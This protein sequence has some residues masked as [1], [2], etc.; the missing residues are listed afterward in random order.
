[1]RYDFF[2]PG[3]E[4]MFEVTKSVAEIYGKKQI[5]GFC[6]SVMQRDFSGVRVSK[7]TKQYGR[8][9][10]SDSLAMNPNQI[11][12]HRKL[13]PDI[14]VTKEGQP[15]FDNYT[16]HLKYLDA[17]N[18]VKMPKSKKKKGKRIA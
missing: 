3:C 7:G 5:C 2:C 9:I 6:G 13:F 17:C 16:E 11:V 15:V 12:E 18:I 10:V 8:K 4:E 14:Q 1:M